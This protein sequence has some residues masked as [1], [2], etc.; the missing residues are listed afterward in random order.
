MQ[1]LRDLQWNPGNLNN[2]LFDPRMLQVF[3]LML[4]VK[5]QNQNNEAS[6]PKSPA[7]MPSKSSPPPPHQQKTHLLLVSCWREY[8]RLMFEQNESE[9]M[10]E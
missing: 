10:Q 2:Y 7:P 6:E 3:S 9:K 1:M 8:L 4:Y 5:V